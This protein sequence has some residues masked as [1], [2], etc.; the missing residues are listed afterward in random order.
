M[1]V[2]LNTAMANGEGF[3][4]SVAANG[5]DG[6]HQRDFVFD[7]VKIDGVLYVGANNGAPSLRTSWS[8]LAR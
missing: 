7:V 2:Y 5:S 6:F 1:K 3:Q 4:Y 8:C